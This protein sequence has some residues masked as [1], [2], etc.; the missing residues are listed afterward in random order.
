MRFTII[1]LS[2]SLA[3]A[4][5]RA[6]TSAD[7]TA[8]APATG[9]TTTAAGMDRGPAKDAEHEFLRKMTDHHE[10][11]I[12]MA[13]EAMT[14][15]SKPATQGDAHNLHTKQAAERDS[16]VAMLRTAY[17]ETHMPKVMEKTR[18]QND[19]LQR[20]SGAEYDRTFYR[21]VVAHHREGLAMIDSLMP[22]LTKNDVKR[23]AEKMKA[24][25][26]K[27]ITDFQRKASGD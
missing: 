4:C 17:S 1:L 24:D 22:R 23:M 14:K 26:Q 19:S 15:A 9:A 13:T 16:M 27:E 8:A 5:G 25:Q 10:G 20:M 18:A 21:M 2:M 7:T 3:A 6:D 11:L 12:A